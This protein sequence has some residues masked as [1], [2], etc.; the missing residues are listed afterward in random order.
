M[1]RSYFLEPINISSMTTL[2]SL[3]GKGRSRIIF[4]IEAILFKLVF[5]MSNP[6]IIH[7][8]SSLFVKLQCHTT[9]TTFEKDAVVVVVGEED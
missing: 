2:N 1:T 7:F 6:I 3:K 8:A 4:R 5:I 9:S